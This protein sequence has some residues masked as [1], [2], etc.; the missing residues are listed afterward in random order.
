VNYLCHAWDV[1]S[2]TELAKLIG[3]LRRAMLRI[4][5]AEDLPD[6]PAAQIELLRVLA[7]RGPTTPGQVAARL[8]VSPPT[9]S[10]L[11]R[12]MTA[13]GLV[14]RS[15]DTTDLRVVHLAASQEAREVLDR[16]NHAITAA[17]R[18]AIDGLTPQRRKAFER[19]LPALAD[20]LGALADPRSD[21]GRD[22]HLGRESPVATQSTVGG[23]R[24]RSTS[25]ESHVR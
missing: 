1:D 6:L 9:V 2:A 15:Q 13:A 23:S 11:V 21:G 14:E 16:Y 17:M 20:I 7:E 12:S 24:R 5:L 10:N 3:P 19:A 22:C 8:R 25:G 4:R 18:N